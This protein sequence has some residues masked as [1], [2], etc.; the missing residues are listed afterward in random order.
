M[1]DG[2]RDIKCMRSP[3]GVTR[4]LRQEEQIDH[5]RQLRLGEDEAVVPSRSADVPLRQHCLA[6]QLVAAE[7]I[8]TFQCRMC[9]SP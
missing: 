3:G 6:P 9:H 8:K 7:L 5:M 2:V 1:D 4:R